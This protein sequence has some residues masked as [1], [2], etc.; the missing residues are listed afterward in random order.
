MTNLAEIESAIQKLPQVEIRQL[1]DRLQAY[2]EAEWDKQIE[3]DAASGKLDALISRAEADI[4]A[5]WVKSL[6]ES[7]DDLDEILADCQMSTGIRD[8]A[9]QHDHYRLGTPKRED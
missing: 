3:T 5:G 2:L 6:D 1:V 9:H 4:D 7:W 8:L